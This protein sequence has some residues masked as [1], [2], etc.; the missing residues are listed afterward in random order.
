M[1]ILKFTFLTF[2]FTVLLNCKNET[3]AEVEHEDEVEVEVETSKIIP[4]H[5]A[6]LVI[7]TGDHVIYVDPTGGSE[8]F[9]NQKKPTLVLITD[10]HGNH[11]SVETL[12]DLKLEN[13]LTIVPQAVAD[14]L[15]EN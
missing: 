13:V 14:Q 15:P 10:I 12:E 7:E 1:K 2:L 4:I 11:L 3:K 6:T 8:A 9:Q 5:H